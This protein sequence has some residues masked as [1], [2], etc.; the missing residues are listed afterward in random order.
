MGIESANRAYAQAGIG[1]FDE[2]EAG[3]HESAARAA[4]QGLD[5]LHYNVRMLHVELELLR[6]RPEAARRVFEK[7]VAERAGPPPE[8]SAAEFAHQLAE[9]QLALAEGRSEL[10]LRVFGLALE[11]RQ[12]AAGTIN[13]LLGRSRAHCVAGAPDAGQTDARDAL[14]F[15]RQL[16]GQRPSSFRTGLAWLALAQAQAQLG[17]VVQARASAHDAV[18]A[19][20]AQMDSRHPALA[21]A[22]ALAS[23]EAARESMHAPGVTRRRAH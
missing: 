22:R 13:A 11:D 17:A 12:P 9:A 6:R 4:E 8:G 1:L 21:D 10:A 7:A 20:V 14:A 19:L 23:G 16:Q 15:A 18:A 5:V 2:A 3:Y